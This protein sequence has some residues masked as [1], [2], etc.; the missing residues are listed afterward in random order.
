MEKKTQ[1]AQNLI[2]KKQLASNAEVMLSSDELNRLTM[3]FSLLIQI[4]RRTNT[5]K[6][7]SHEQQ[8]KRDRSNTHQTD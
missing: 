7:Y 6:R 8:N 4:D 1:S 3:F 2:T 5:T